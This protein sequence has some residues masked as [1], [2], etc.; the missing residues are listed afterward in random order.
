M[1]GLRDQLA[2][3]RLPRFMARRRLQ[4]EAIHG[5]RRLY[6]LRQLHT[7][8]LEWSSAHRCRWQILRSEE[9][10]T[11]KAHQL[12]STISNFTVS[13]M[14][15]HLP[16]GAEAPILFAVMAYCHRPPCALWIFTRC[17]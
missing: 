10:R 3:V 12:L 16:C 15:L 2:R 11:M 7:S 8:T 13:V 5:P 1:A 17:R 4:P 9:M 14:L 6:L